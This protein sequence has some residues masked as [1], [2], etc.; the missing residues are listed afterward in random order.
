MVAYGTTGT[1]KS[2]LCNSII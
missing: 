1:G 2:T